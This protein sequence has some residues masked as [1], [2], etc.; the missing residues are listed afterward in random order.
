MFIVNDLRIG[1]FVI[2]A[3][4]IAKKML[5]YR[6]WRYS[7]SAPNIKKIEKGD[8]VL[9]YLAGKERGYFFASFRLV[10]YICAATSNKNSETM[11]SKDLDSLFPLLSLI[12]N[13]Q[14]YDSPIIL[15]EELRTKLEFIVD[16]KNWGLHF[17]QS[18]RT[19][20]E[21][22]ADIITSAVGHLLFMADQTDRHGLNG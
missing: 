17:R 13:I 10:D 19:L 14:I 3:E 11:W 16:K 22:D 15:N 20:P 2:S 8:S 18:I 7:K 9:V 12:D 5:Q 1:N 6:V 4:D 21:R